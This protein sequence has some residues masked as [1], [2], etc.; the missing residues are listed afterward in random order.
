MSPVHQPR[1]LATAANT[2]SGVWSTVMVVVKP[3]MV[4]SFVRR[5]IAGP[6]FRHSN[7]AQRAQLGH[8]AGIGRLA[9]QDG[10]DG[11]GDRPAQVAAVERGVQDQGARQGEAAAGSAL[12]R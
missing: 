11:G 4:S 6:E 3:F 8:E 5:T 10:G 7:Q 2:S 1:T 9:V 12:H